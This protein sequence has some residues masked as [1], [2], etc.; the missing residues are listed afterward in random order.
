MTERSSLWVR[1]VESFLTQSTMISLSDTQQMSSL[2]C[3][4]N[5]KLWFSQLLSQSLSCPMR[6]IFRD[7]SNRQ[8]SSRKSANSRWKYFL[9]SSSSQIFTSPLIFSV[10]STHRSLI[11]FHIKRSKSRKN[12]KKRKKNS[13]LPQIYKKISRENLILTLSNKFHVGGWQGFAAATADV[14]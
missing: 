4:E 2:I 14:A 1:E 13:S 8:L 5:E 3:L 10:R 9:S 12:N 6:K 7:V 11:S